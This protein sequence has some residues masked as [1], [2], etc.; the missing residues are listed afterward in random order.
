MHACLKIQLSL[1]MQFSTSFDMPRYAEA[2]TC[3]ENLI[4]S[5]S[6]VVFRE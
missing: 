2:V 3:T 6:I 5:A 1:E 4:F